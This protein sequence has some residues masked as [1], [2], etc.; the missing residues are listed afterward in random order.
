MKSEGV[1]DEDDEWVLDVSLVEFSVGCVDAV[2]GNGF[3]AAVEELESE[4]TVLETDFDYA[5]S[6]VS[7]I[8]Q[9]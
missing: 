7:I 2:V 4:D 1:E 9:E 5:T 6:A 3:T 8:S